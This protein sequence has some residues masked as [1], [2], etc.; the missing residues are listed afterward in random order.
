MRQGLA[1]IDRGERIAIE[2]IG[3]E[4][5]SW[6]IRQPSEWPYRGPG[7]VPLS[8][9][10]P[11]AAQAPAQTINEAEALK[12]KES[13]CCQATAYLAFT[14]QPALGSALPE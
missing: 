9:A 13:V 14:T 2:E 6:V 7:Q 5:P 4:L 12:R 11:Q 8:G 3:R 1:E 10:R